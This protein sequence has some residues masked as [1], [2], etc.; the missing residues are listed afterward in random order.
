M[1]GATGAS[2]C[3]HPASMSPS[4]A[5]SSR[6]FGISGADRRHEHALLGGEDA[7]DAA[8]PLDPEAAVAHDQRRALV[9]AEPAADEPGLDG[10]DQA[11]EHAALGDV[12]LDGHA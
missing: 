9:D 8:T 5:S 6:D 1:R 4:A 11:G 10:S 12:H 2:A 7:P 3:A